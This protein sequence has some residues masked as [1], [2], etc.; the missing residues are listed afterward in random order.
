MQQVRNIL[1][2]MLSGLT[3]LRMTAATLAVLAVT[4][5]GVLVVAQPAGASAYNCYGGY[6]NSNWA[7]GTC[8]GASNGWG[9]FALTAQCW[10]WGANTVY[11]NAPQTIYSHCPWWS[12]I[13]RIIVQPSGF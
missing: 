4:A 6:I 2:A 7:W 3:G 5:A 12:H 10:A 8:K 1:K 13:T 9:G 11:G